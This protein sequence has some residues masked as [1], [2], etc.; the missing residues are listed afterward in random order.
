MTSNRGDIDLQ[1]PWFKQT[2]KFYCMFLSESIC[3][4]NVDIKADFKDWF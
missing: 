4:R 3:N 2:A 1:F